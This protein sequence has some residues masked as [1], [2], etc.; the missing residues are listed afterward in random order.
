M[1]SPA[2]TTRQHLLTTFHGVFDLR[3]IPCNNMA[4]VFLFR[5]THGILAL[6][7]CRK[8]LLGVLLGGFADVVVGE[9][10]RLCLLVASSWEM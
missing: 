1:E 8:L 10:A 6:I 4:M 2:R 3:T 9:R 7:Q 5:S